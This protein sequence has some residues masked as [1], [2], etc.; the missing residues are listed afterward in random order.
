MKRD[1]STI[2]IWT[3]DREYSCLHLSIHISVDVN[4]GRLG[5][6]YVRRPVAVSLPVGGG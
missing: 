1:K 6:L 2:T 3:S 5:M 4:V